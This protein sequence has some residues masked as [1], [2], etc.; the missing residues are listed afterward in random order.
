MREERLP[1]FPLQ[2]VLFPGSAL[3]LHI[4]ED[5]YKLLIGR[6]LAE[7]TA[8][9]INFVNGNTLADVG[10]TA[11][12]SSV[13]HRYDDG[14]LDVIVE[15]KRTYRLREYDD[16]ATPYLVGLVQYLD[17]TPEELD[18]LLAADVIGLYNRIVSRAHRGALPPLGETDMSAGVSFLM[19]Q[20]AGMELPQR[21]TL[22]ETPSENAR[23]RL[24]LEYFRGLLPRLET[25]AELDRIAR[26]DGYVTPSS[27]ENS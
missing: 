13:L 19:A 20:K 1:L 10:C 4:F 16:R 17:P 9:G 23:L 3:P 15:G 18:R 14:R 2:V 8:F 26:N 24:L 11:M 27:S 7:K 6:S 25:R 12:V 5:R 21:Q 22:L